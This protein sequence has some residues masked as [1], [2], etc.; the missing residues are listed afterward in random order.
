MASA[1]MSII[2]EKFIQ[3][4]YGPVDPSFKYD[5]YKN[6]VQYLD[7]WLLETYVTRPVSHQLNQLE[8]YFSTE[9][10]IGAYCPDSEFDKVE[11]Y[12]RYLYRLQTLSYLFQSLREHE[13]LTKKFQFNSGCSVEWS[14]F[15]KQC[16]PKSS[17]MKRFL[18]DSGLAFSNL[19]TLRVP[20]EESSKDHY[21]RWLQNLK[22]NNPSSLTQYRLLNVCKNNCVKAK[23][24]NLSGH[25]SRV[26]EEEKKLF[27]NICSEEDLIYG[28]SGVEEAFELISTSVGIRGINQ[29]GYAVGCLKRFVQENKMSEAY[30]S[31]MLN[32]I[33]K[34]L[35]DYNLNTKPNRA[36]GILYEVGSNKEFTDK[37]L[38]QL[39][40]PPKKKAEL[41]VKKVA[42]KSAVEVFNPEFEKI[43]LPEFEPKKIVKT[44][45]KKV[46]AKKIEEPV[47]KKSSFAISSEFRE[48]YNLAE[49]EVDLERFKYDYVFSLSTIEKLKPKIEIF[50]QVS[51]LRAMK[52]ND[53]LGTQA[54]PIPLR[55]IKFLIE[56]EEHKSLF[57]IIMVLGDSFYI[58]NDIDENISKKDVIKINNNEATN[59]KWKMHILE[60]L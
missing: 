47:V 32:N 40:V 37:G 49:V 16:S 13:Y 4:Y 35:Y 44:K 57:N 41:P 42:Q 12:I 24:K 59:F 21:M 60:K 8:N 51:S 19:K 3:D 28:L 50:S 20:F 30:P 46:V 5:A 38:A 43:E 29:N 39:F 23:K 1:S 14:Q 53:K 54:A 34:V 26:C 15:V 11:T 27:L 10:F 56:A 58:F 22:S 33:F 52:K 25:I 9:F 7:D 31:R 48:K 17:E 55:F 6:E 36:Q 2:G 45:P 18:K